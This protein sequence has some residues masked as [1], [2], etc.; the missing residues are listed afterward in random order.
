MSAPCQ[1]GAG[2][3]ADLLRPPPTS[4]VAN[5]NGRETSQRTERKVSFNA[6]RLPQDES[7]Q[8]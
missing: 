8:A 3:G 6:G 5:P 4:A 2:A 1:A 7:L